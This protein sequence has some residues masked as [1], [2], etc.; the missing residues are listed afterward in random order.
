M[1]K[2]IKWFIVIAIVVMLVEAFNNFVNPETED[3]VYL[4]NK[5]KAEMESTL[6]CSLSQ[7]DTMASRIYAYT[8]GELTLDWNSD[9]GFG[10]IYIDDKQAGIHTDNRL[11]SMY[12]I[13]IGD[14]VIGVKDDITFSYDENFEVLDDLYGGSSTATFYYNNTRKDC[15]VV[16]AND[17]TN[18]VVALSYYTDG[19]KATEQLKPL[20]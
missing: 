15:L 8:E 12:N 17:T 19:K 2:L 4:A 7:N 3:I 14:P 13:K 16:I 1:K 10:I 5:T 18:R 11:Y 9:E 20:Y 6:G